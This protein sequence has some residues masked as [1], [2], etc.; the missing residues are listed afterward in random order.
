MDKQRAKSQHDISRKQFSR[1]G[2][3]G[4]GRT[5]QDKTRQGQI[6]VAGLGKARRG[7]AT[8]DKA[9]NNFRGVAGLGKARRGAATQDKD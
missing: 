9:R 2:W 7:A 8:Q 6:S 4:R 5:R 3:A 1:L